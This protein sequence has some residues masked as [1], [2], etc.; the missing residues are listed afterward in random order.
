MPGGFSS[1]AIFKLYRRQALRSLDVAALSVSERVAS[2]GSMSVV[3]IFCGRTLLLHPRVG[4]A[5]TWRVRRAAEAA[6]AYGRGVRMVSMQRTDSKLR[7]PYSICH[8]PLPPRSLHPRRPSL[9]HRC[10]DSGSSLKSSESKYIGWNWSRQR[11]M[12]QKGIVLWRSYERSR[13]ASSFQSLG[14]DVAHG[15]GDGPAKGGRG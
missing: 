1:R 3:H 5:G 4:Y 8:S 13:Q 6:S 2:H 11:T 10:H 14:K 7:T 12:V 9:I 15:I